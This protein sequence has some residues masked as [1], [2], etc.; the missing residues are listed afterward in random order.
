MCQKFCS[1]G[2]GVFQH[3]VSKGVCIPACTGHWGI[4]PTGG[5]TPP[6][7]PEA[8]NLPGTRGRHP[9]GR[10]PPGQTPSSPGQTPLGT[11]GRHPTPPRADTPLPDGHCSGRYAS[12]WNAFLYYECFLIMIMSD[13]WSSVQNMIYFII[14]I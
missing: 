12:Y 9:L 2:R 7:R 1:R 13:K 4:Y 3:A 5:Y 6:T 10:H 14:S 11:G 8:D